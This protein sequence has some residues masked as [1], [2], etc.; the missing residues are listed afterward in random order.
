L[1]IVFVLWWVGWIRVAHC[2]SFV[3]GW[4]DPWGSLF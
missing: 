3:T 1:F 2:F 4:L